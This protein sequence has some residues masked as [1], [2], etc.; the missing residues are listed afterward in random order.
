[1]HE[2]GLTQSILDIAIEHANR[3]K[4]SKILKINVRAGR[5]IALVDESMQFFFKYLTGGTIAEGADLV[6][7]HI[8]IRIY[9]LACGVN[10][11]VSEFEI[12]SCPKCGGSEVEIV[13]GREFFV[14]SIEVE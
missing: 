14:D 6:I 1:M 4:A 7:E 8:P 10:S 13:S 11:E 5:M 2:L 3:N 9:C 12:Y